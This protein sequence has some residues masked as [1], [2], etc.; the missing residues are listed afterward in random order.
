MRR[1]YE[2]VAF[3][4][5]NFPAIL[6]GRPRA[7]CLHTDG[8][9]SPHSALDSLNW[10]DRERAFS[11]HYYVEANGVIYAGVDPTYHAWHVKESRKAKERG[12]EVKHPEIAGE[13]GDIGVI[14]IEHVQDETGH[15]SQET[16]I[17]S[18]LLV[19]DLLQRWPELA[20]VEH[21]DLDPWNRPNDVGDALHLGDFKADLADLDRGLEPWRTVGEEATGTPRPDSD[22]PPLTI[23]PDDTA[24]WPTA[25]SV[26]ED[27]V[28][29]LEG[30]VIA[31][32]TS[33]TRLREHL[34]EI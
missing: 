15:W 32:T 3:E 21:A 18:L 26:L 20:I 12:W 1:D 33:L 17:S 5:E 8:N 31:L 22:R 6:T 13:R 9:P 29:E 10:G 19:H 34:R 28:D 30:A 27:R 4:F 11:I 24:S 2:T 14:G 16:R 23:V 7:V 25:L